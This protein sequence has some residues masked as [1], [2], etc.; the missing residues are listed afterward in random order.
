MYSNGS[1]PQ[2]RTKMTSHTAADLVDEEE[3]QRCAL[4]RERL[5]QLINDHFFGEGSKLAQRTGLNQSLISQYRT[6]KRP[7][8]PRTTEVI[9]KTLS[10]HGYF[11]VADVGALSVVHF[12]TIT[13]EAEATLIHDYRKLDSLE[14]RRIAL[15][16]HYKA[17]LAELAREEAT[18]AASVAVPDT[19]KTVPKLKNARRTA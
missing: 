10:M 9:E 15:E 8:S 7:I 1:Y 12:P 14:Q 19:T 18:V 16:L 13:S 17:G 2:E 6:G 5:N 4:R 3:A 11:S